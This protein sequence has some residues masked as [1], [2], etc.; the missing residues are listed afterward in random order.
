VALANLAAGLDIV[1]IDEATKVDVVEMGRLYYDT[2]ERL[3][4]D[5]LRG[6]TRAMPVSTSWQSLAAAAMLDDFYAL[7]RDI[8]QRVLA[9][10]DGV[11]NHRLEAW[12]A[13]RQEAVGRIQEM[14]AEIGRAGPA[15]LAML[16]VASRQLRAL[17]AN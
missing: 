2:G 10:S 15:D 6:S 12:M 5:A 16:T 7:Q 14:I 17:T 1:R 3:G 8:V 13:R 11:G 4:L 9:E